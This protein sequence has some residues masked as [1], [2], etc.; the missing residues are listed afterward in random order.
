VL[1]RLLQDETIVPAGV[2]GTSAGAMNAAVLATG[3][4]RG[5]HRG[6][7]E[8]LA[9]FWRDIAT[10]GSCFGNGVPKAG[11]PA[12]DAAF[13][14]MSAW[15]WA[16]A[17]TRSW[18]QWAWTG[19]A[20]LS[21]FASPYQFNPLGLNPLREVVARHV[22]EQLMREGPLRVFV[23]ATAVHTGQPEV[24]SGG[25]LS[26]EAL[27]ASACLPHLFHAV[28]I[29]G[30]PYWDGGYTGNPAIWPLIYE[31]EPL[32]VL[33]IKINPLRRDGT[34]DT[35]M[36]IA[37]RVS[38]ITFNAGLV[39]ELRAIA[40]VQRLLRDQ[41]LDPGHYKGLRLHMVHDEDG[42]APLGASSKLNTDWDFLQSLHALGVAA[43]ERWLAAH[44]ADL[45][46][47]P[48]LDV[49]ATFLARRA[50]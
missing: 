24:F 5:G 41:Q 16:D 46:V 39:G 43:A 40:F 36:E 33:L 31:T 6:A 37:D 4:A 10:T 11:T 1:D 34:P 38:E 9:A 27:L 25:R 28:E 2:S 45:G 21:K 47:R 44:R 3:F 50:A 18:R 22:S 30:V 15:P 48:T 42:L 32:D 49:A 13:P 14:W 7:R 8:A 23:T 35:P 19:S 17:W 29:G 12:F 20:V 26:H